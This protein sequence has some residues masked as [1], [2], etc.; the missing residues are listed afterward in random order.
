MAIK[1]LSIPTCGEYNAVGTKVTYSNPYTA[2]HAVEYSF[3][4]ETSDDNELYADN[5]VKESSTGKFNTGTLTLQTADLEPALSMK[6][7]G[8]KEVSRTVNGKEVLEIVYDD[9]QEAPP[10]GFGI[11]EEHQIDNVTKY[12]PIIFAKVVFNI[13]GNAATTRGAEVD[14]QTKEITAKVMRSEHV[15]ENYKYPWQFSPKEL[16]AT[17]EE[18]RDYMEYVLGKV[19]EAGK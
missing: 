18:A 12:L 10:L 19:P 17:E 14:W 6:L 7:L 9:D 8:L 16:F 4:A 15:D 1:G 3:E 11:I 5:R 2:D 13:P